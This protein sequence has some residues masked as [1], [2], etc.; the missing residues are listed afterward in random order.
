MTKKTDSLATQQSSNVLPSRRQALGVI[1]AFSAFGAMVMLSCGDDDSPGSS[2]PGSGTTTDAGSDPGF[3]A[4]GGTAAMTAA[5]SYPNPF[6]SGIG[7]V[8]KLACEATLGPCYANT[9]VRKDISEGH[10]GL[11]VRLAFLVVDESCKPIEGA[12]VDIWHAAPEGLYSGDD[13]STFCTADDPSATSAR[14]FRGVQ[15][16]DANGRAD[17]DTCF[18]GWYSSRT[19]HIHFTIR[20]NGSEYVTSQLVFD[21]A[22]NDDVINTQPLYK[23]RGPRDTTNAT[24]NVVSA[25]SAPDYMFQT[26][27]MADGAMLAWKTLVIRSS[28]SDPSCQMPGGGGGGGGPPPG[29]DGGMGP[30]PGDGG[31]RPPRGD[32]GM[33]PPPGSD[34]GV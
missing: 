11:P 5:A 12:S 9:L 14:W 17:F 20:V 8:C 29:G 22:L 32:G 30:P 18:P 6:A 25:E 15:T 13:A 3:W 4:T 7:S 16:T 10:N 33:G 19:I 34:A 21:D 27:R 1:G 24:D 23:D 31:I 26:Q 28:L 2:N